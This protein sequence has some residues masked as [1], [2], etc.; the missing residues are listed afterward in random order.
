MSVEGGIGVKDAGTDMVVVVPP[1]RLAN[2]SSLLERKITQIR[3]SDQAEP[4]AFGVWAVCR[5]TGKHPMLV[6][7]FVVHPA[8]DSLSQHV[9]H[10]MCA[11]PNS[12][13]IHIEA[14][15]RLVRKR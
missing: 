7:G 15:S 4:L 13:N 5:L 9:L 12:D 11:V 1:Q 2:R 14:A 3:H 8:P 10:E 6:Q